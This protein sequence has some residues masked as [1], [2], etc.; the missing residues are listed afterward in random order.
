M[1]RNKC[2]IRSLKI[3]SIYKGTIVL[4][5]RGTNEWS[6]WGF[7]NPLK[8]C[9]KKGKHVVQLVLEDFDDNMNGKVNQA[10]I[11]YMRII[12]IRE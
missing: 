5:Q 1:Q 12:R 8:V 10:M 3:D 2:A 7:S 11:D 9:L 6:N 4:P